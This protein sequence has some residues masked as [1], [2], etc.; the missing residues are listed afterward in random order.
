LEGVFEHGAGRELPAGVVQ[1]LVF[2]AQPFSRVGDFEQGLLVVGYWAAEMG[3][4][5]E[6]QLPR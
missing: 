5:P 2:L 4:N 1:K 3:T 6:G